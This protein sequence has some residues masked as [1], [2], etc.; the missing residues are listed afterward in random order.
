[1]LESRIA[2]H[3]CT[4]IHIW[5]A[6][7]VRTKM[8]A[9]PKSR[10]G[11]GTQRNPAP[12]LVQLV[13]T[14]GLSAVLVRYPH[15]KVFVYLLC[16]IRNAKSVLY[17]TCHHSMF[18][19]V[20]MRDSQDMCEQRWIP[21]QSHVWVGLLS[22]SRHHVLYNLR[23]RRERVLYSYVTCVHMFVHYFMLF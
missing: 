20:Y 7:H 23:Q 22:E 13:P 19:H 17:C 21:Y 8:D 9:I 1:M 3:V 4:C 10:V 18:T 14:M 11:P 2:W 15:I 6:T 12:C 16:A 5:Q